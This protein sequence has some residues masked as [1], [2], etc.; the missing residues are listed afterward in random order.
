MQLHKL[1]KT[2]NDKSGTVHTGP[3]PKS[4]VLVHVPRLALV[5]RARA[6]SCPP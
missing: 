1:E 2:D 5:R 4:H 6:A 3:P